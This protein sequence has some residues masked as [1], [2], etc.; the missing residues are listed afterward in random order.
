MKTTRLIT[1]LALAAGIAALASCQKSEPQTEAAKTS[2]P[3]LLTLRVGTATPDAPD[4]KVSYTDNVTTISASWEVGD[5][6]S[7][8]ELDSSN[9]VLSNTVF[10]AKTAGSTAEFEGTYAKSASAVSAVVLYPALTEGAGTETDKWRSAAY[11]TEGEGR[12]F[13]DCY[14]GYE[15]ITRGSRNMFQQTDGSTDILKNAA[16]QATV[17]DLSSVGTSLDVALS[18]ACY[19]IKA[20]LNVVGLDKVRC[21]SVSSGSYLGVWGWDKFPSLDRI[22]DARDFTTYLGTNPKSPGEASYGVAPTGGSVTV[23]ILCYGSTD[24]TVAKDEEFK[25]EA[26]GIASGV[27]TTLSYTSASRSTDITLKPGYMYT[28]G[29]TLN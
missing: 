24:H 19:V 21:V 12:V 28:L 10:T 20:K 14:V 1:T 23:Y 29:K 18:Y 27:D 3:V 11:N 13:R 17:P 15:Y 8:I 2:G 7:L 26:V 4:T 22:G 25:V 6:L 5:K 16:M 9:K